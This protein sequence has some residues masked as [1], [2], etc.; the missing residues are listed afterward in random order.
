LKPHFVI[1]EGRLAV[2]AFTKAQ[3]AFAIRDGREGREGGVMIA[4]AKTR[5][6]YTICKG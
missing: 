6:F 1:R 3:G 2:G 4:F 5:D